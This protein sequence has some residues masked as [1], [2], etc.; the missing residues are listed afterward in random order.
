LGSQ[1]TFKLACKTTVATI[2]CA[3]VSRS[4]G[5]WRRDLAI[6]PDLAQTVLECI[7]IEQGFRKL[8][9]EK[10]YRRGPLLRTPREGH[11][12]RHG[13]QET[14]EIATLGSGMP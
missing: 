3:T 12:D 1:R 14:D 2:V 9:M 10:S 7:C 6:N 8:L 13:T 11:G 5:H 4:T